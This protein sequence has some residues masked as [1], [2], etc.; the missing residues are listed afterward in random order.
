MTHVDITITTNRYDYYIVLITEHELGHALG[1]GHA[2]YPFDIMYP[3]NLSGA[4]ITSLDLYAVSL[5]TIGSWRNQVT[6]PKSIPYLPVPAEAVPEFPL[7]PLTVFCLGTAL[8]LLR[9]RKRRRRPAL[10]D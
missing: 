4:A 7:M 1:L 6:L 8:M 3:D 9:A 10:Q 5:L 2:T